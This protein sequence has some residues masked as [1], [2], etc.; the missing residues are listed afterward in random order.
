MMRVCY[1]VCGCTVG[2]VEVD[3]DF[4]ARVI[5]YDLVQVLT[6]HTHKCSRVILVFLLIRCVAVCVGV[7]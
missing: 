2:E 5:K 1:S 4:A 6:H 3:N 7:V